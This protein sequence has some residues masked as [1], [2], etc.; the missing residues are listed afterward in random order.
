[1][2]SQLQNHD[3]MGYTIRCSVG[4]S[5]DEKLGGWCRVDLGPEQVPEPEVFDAGNVSKLR[6]GRG[7]GST[8]GFWIA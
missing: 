2:K 7:L 4:E 5:Q 1:M 6:G 3:K 8:K